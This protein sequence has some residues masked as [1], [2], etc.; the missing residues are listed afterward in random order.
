MW[1]RIYRRTQAL[2]NALPLPRTISSLRSLIGTLGSGKIAYYCTHIRAVSSNKKPT[3]WEDTLISHFQSLLPAWIPPTRDNVV[4]AT[5]AESYSAEIGDV[6]EYLRQLKS[7]LGIGQEGFPADCLLVADQEVHAIVKKLKK[8]GS[9]YDWIHPYPGEWYELK[10]ASEVLRDL[11]WD[12][13]L[14]QLASACGHKGELKQWQDIYYLLLA[15]YEA[16]LREGVTEFGQHRSGKDQECTPF[17]GKEFWQWITSLREPDNKNEV[18]RFWATALIHLHA[19]VG[20]Y[21]AIRS[22][23]WHLRNSTVKCFV[24]LFFAYGGDKYQQLS[25]ESFADFHTFP[26]HV[27]KPLVNAGELVDSQSDRQAPPKSCPG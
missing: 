3:Q 20:F 9:E 26:A 4:L 6:E 27:A 2:L 5:V 12:G 17:H 8:H 18:S 13:G 16:L 15:L 7:D 24:P 25:M 1:L 11:L 10:L 22:G 14:Q 19:Y 21:L 23:N